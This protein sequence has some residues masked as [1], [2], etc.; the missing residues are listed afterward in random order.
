[1][2][3]LDDLLGPEPGGDLPEHYELARALVVQEQRASTSWLQRQMVI[4]YNKAANIME[5]LEARGVVS[6]AN[7]LG[8]R[9]VLEAREE[10]APTVAMPRAAKTAAKTPD[11]P[12]PQT[13]QS[14]TDAGV[15]QALLRPISISFLSDV[16]LKDRKAITRKL[17]NL[18]PMAQYRGNVPL[19]DF[20]QAL[21]YLVTPK[22]DAAD[23]IRKMGVNDLPVGLQKD[24]WD[25]KLKQQK[26]MEQAGDL[27]KTEEVLEVLGEAFQR[28]KTTTQLWI[29]QVAETHS[30]SP[31]VRSDLTKMVDGLQKD[32]HSTLVEMPTEKSTRSQLGEIEGSDLDV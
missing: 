7:T 21:E 23:L 5:A 24:V 10:E 26:W 30:L 31:E 3:D 14:H 13:K 1:M 20:R 12:I 28:L 15:V 29:D 32:L 9:E 19:Y 8:K 25:A 16:L 4:G 18:T 27:W 2:S 17:A 11:K 22:M 6:S